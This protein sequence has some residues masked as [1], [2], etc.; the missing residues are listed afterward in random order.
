M[1]NQELNM[2]KNTTMT[3]RIPPEVSDELDA[4]ARD[5]KRTKAY[6]A[7]EAITDYVKRNAWQVARIRERLE[8]AKSGGPGI[9]HE[10]IERWMDTWDTDHEL[11][12]PEPKS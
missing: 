10:E 11:P 4:L 12:A 5:T 1:E 6:L 9:P 2:G 8:E 7:G 3:V